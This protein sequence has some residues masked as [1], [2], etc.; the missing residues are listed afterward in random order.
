MNIVIFDIL[1]VLDL[2]VY[3]I[4]WYILGLHLWIPRDP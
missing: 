4:Q 2:E 1:L 3:L